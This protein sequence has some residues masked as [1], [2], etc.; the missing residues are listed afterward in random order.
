MP[1]PKRRGASVK[2]LAWAWG[3]TRPCLV[4][5][6][7]SPARPHAR[8]SCVAWSRNASSESKKPHTLRM[9]T[10][11]WRAR[12]GGGRAGEVCVGMWVGGRGTRHAVQRARAPSSRSPHPPPPAPPPPPPPPPPIPRPHRL[13]VKPQLIPGRNLQG[14]IEGA[15]PAGEGDKS[16]GLV[17][18]HRLALVHVV[19]HAYFAARGP[20]DLARRERRWD[21]P[22]HRQPRRRHRLCHHAHEPNV[23][24]TVHQAYP[25]PHQLLAQRPRRCRVGWPPSAGPTEHRHLF[26]LGG[27]GG[28]GRGVGAAAHRNGRAGGGGGRASGRAAAAAE[29]QLLRARSEQRVMGQRFT[30]PRRVQHRR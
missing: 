1:R 21:D 25:P 27:G 23:S 26:E 17:K 10:W 16:V 20:G 4:P 2:R 8:T 3:G 13:G 12:E 29:A 11:V 19:H 15:I 18:H 9:P 6:T 28:R 14:L 22:H 30:L 5:L 7:R 24:P